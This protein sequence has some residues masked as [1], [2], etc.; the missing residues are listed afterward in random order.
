MLLRLADF[1]V[2]FATPCEPQGPRDV[3]IFT[4][5]EP[6]RACANAVEPLLF[7]AASWQFS[8]HLQMFWT[9]LWIFRGHS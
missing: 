2:T 8:E 1:L 4:F 7:S 9:I 6:T 5:V 3:R